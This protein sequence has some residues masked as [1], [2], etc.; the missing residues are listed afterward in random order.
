MPDIDLVIDFFLKFIPSL[1]LELLCTKW[2]NTFSVRYELED[3]GG[4]LYLLSNLL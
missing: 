4:E 3:I 2:I 1:W